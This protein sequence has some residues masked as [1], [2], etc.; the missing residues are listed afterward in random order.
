MVGLYIEKKT[1]VFLFRSYTNIIPKKLHV[2]MSRGHLHFG[3]EQIAK[4]KQFCSMIFVVV[5]LKYYAVN[6]KEYTKDLLFFFCYYCNLLQHYTVNK[7]VKLTEEN[8]FAPKFS[9]IFTM[10]L[11]NCV[12]VTL[13]FF[14]QPH[15]IF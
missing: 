10:T 14:S 6:K 5:L 3:I 11:L 8:I 7:S 1:G 2:E 4:T 12:I 13:T 9:W 15:C